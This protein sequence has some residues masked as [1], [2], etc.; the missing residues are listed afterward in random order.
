MLSIEQTKKILGK[1][2]DGLTDEQP[3]EIRDGYYHLVNIIF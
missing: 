2:A 1:N 3:T